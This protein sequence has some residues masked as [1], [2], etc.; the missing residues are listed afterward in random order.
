RCTKAAVH[1]LQAEASEP[2]NPTVG[3]FAGC[4]ARAASGHAAVAPPSAASNSRRPMV[5]VIRPSR[6]RCVKGRIPR[7]GR[8]VLTFQGGQDAGSCHP[9]SGSKAESPS[10]PLCPRKRT[11]L[12]ILE[13][14]PPPALGERC[15]RLETP[16]PQVAADERCCRASG[17][18]P[19]IDPLFRE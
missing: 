16:P 4:C 2:K 12:P 5:T 11:Y 1:G 7:H 8:A 9:A 19:T 18:S 15:H 17:A 13:R 6:A 14:I 10:F 3:S